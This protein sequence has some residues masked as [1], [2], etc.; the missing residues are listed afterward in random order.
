MHFGLTLFPTDYSILPQDLAREAEN[1]DFESIWFPEHTHI[2]A[3]RKT[4][5]PA[6]GDLPEEYW[7]TLDPFAALAAAAAV[8]RTIRLAT[9]ICLL[10]ERDTIITA[11]EAATIDHLSG[12]RFLFGVGAGWNAEEMENHGT[13][14]S[15]R[16][17]KL[18]EQVRAVRAIWREPEPS[19]RGEFVTFERIWC[20]PK[21]V[22]KDGPPVILGGMGTPAMKRVVAYGDGWLPIDGGMGVEALAP[23]L[24][25]FRKLV[26]ASGRAPD[27]VPISVYGVSQ[28]AEAVEKYRQLGVSRV[29]FRLRSETRDLVLP[30]LDRLAKLIG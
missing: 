27:S 30:K 14:F 10:I 6:G 7:H 8:T 20:Y 28:N 16:F 26:A 12:G 4:P 25:E 29:I 17:K 11:H 15:T 18:E 5:Y 21:P 2:P 19:F 3:S 22:Q 24:A 23:M 9:G 1:R 13:V